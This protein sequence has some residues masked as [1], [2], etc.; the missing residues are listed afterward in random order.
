MPIKI[1]CEAI[2]KVEIDVLAPVI[3]AAMD[4]FYS[5]PVRVRDFE[6]WKKNREKE[7][8]GYECN[9]GHKG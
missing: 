4:R 1:I 6:A 9:H 3:L 2:P 5:D 8:K 7:V